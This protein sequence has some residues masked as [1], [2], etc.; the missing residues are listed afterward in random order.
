MDYG[1][2]EA[3]KITMSITFDNALQVNQAGATVGVGE[4]INNTRTPTGTATGAGGL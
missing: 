1:T 2:S 4:V 3:V